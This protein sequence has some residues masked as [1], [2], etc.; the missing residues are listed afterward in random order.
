MKKILGLLIV[1][2]LF[3]LTGCTSEEK[4]FPFDKASCISGWRDKVCYGIDTSSNDAIKAY[5][6]PHSN[7]D[8]KKG[9]YTIDDNGKITLTFGEYDT[10]EYTDGMCDDCSYQ[11]EQLKDLLYDVGYEY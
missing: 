5:K 11:V 6:N 9:T 7:D 2:G 4:E 3:I 8:Y 10:K 1:V